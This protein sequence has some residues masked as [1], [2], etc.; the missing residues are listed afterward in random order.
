MYLGFARELLQLIRCPQDEGVLLLPGGGDEAIRSGEVHCAQCGNVYPIR[1]G[2]LDLMP[3]REVID[4]ISAHEIRSR[5]DEAE[6]YHTYCTTT[7]D[8][9]E[10]PPTLELVA[11]VAGK[12]MVELGCGTGRYSARLSREASQFIGVDF[13]INSLAVLA[14][15]LPS[16]GSTGLVRAD[17]TRFKTVTGHFDLVL[18]AQLLQHLP[19]PEKRED[20]YR[21]VARQLCSGGAFVCNAY[22]YHLSLRLTRQPREG[23]HESGIFYHRFTKQELAEEIGRHLQVESARPISIHIPFSASL[24]FNSVWLSRKLESVPLVNSLGELLLV[25]AQKRD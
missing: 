3:G 17:A 15:S 20:L 10:I 1:N 22:H 23:Y 2:I 6:N 12:K 4:P 13:S 5:D 24:R 11:C 16:G 18:S 14:K 21:N 7:S 19:S 25:K 8:G 9:K